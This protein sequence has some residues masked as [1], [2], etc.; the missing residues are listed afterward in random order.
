MGVQSR[1]DFSAVKTAAIYDSHGRKGKNPLT[2]RAFQDLIIDHLVKDDGYIH[3]T[4]SASYDPVRAM[5]VDLLF[6][7][8]ERTQPEKMER[9]HALYNGGSHETILAKIVSAIGDRGL[10][11]V[12]WNGV[13]FDGGIELDLVCPRPSASF[14][15]K[16][17]GLYSENILSVMDEVYHK[18]G[19]AYRPRSLSQRSCHLHL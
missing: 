3:R 7:F 4:A 11:D 19:G 1:I 18:E 5:D 16:A 17:A 10:V 9:L 15:R 2:E 8:L 13:A 6:D 12:M 14:D